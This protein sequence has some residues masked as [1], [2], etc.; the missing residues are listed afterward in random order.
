[1]ITWKATQV[2]HHTTDSMPFLKIVKS[3]VL[4]PTGG[5]HGIIE[6]RMTRSRS[7]YD[8]KRHYQSESLVIITITLGLCNGATCFSL[9]AFR[10][11]TEEWS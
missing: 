4:S 7:D 10:G 5:W 8:G 9:I 11:S 6:R 2:V 1:M 3:T